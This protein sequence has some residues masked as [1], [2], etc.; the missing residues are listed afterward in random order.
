MVFT[1]SV[2]SVT[3]LSCSLTA[4]KGEKDKKKIRGKVNKRALKRD[5][6]FEVF[7]RISSLYVFPPWIF[8]IPLSL[9]SVSNTSCFYEHFVSEPWSWWQRREGRQVW[10][11]ELSPQS[12]A[13]GIFQ[14]LSVL[15]E[16]QRKA[17]AACWG[18]LVDLT[19]ESHIHSMG[20][21]RERA[22]KKKKKLKRGKK[23]SLSSHTLALSSCRQ[24]APA[25]GDVS[26]TIR[27]HMTLYLDSR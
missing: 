12:Q 1:V 6:A 21:K 10:S 17:I 24:S 3:S 11:L 7:R 15:P 8:L 13:E 22:K 4:E 5:L 20:E 2:F 18:L 16:E 27:Y 25:P 9:S 26:C 14:S 23:S 19:W